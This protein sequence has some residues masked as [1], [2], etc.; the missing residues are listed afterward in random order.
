[1][2]RMKV[3]PSVGPECHS[4]MADPMR[5][6]GHIAGL[7]TIAVVVFASL[8]FAVLYLSS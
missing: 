3:D 2:L 1:M 6:V 5:R 4:T 8:Y 7:M